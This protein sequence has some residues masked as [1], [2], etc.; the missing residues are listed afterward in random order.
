MDGYKKEG[1]DERRK[2]GTKEGREAF[3]EA[4]RDERRKGGMKEGR[5]R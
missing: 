3:K 1:G 5:C 2:G 4:G